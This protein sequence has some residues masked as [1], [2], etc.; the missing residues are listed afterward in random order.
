MNEKE[1]LLK[2]LGIYEKALKNAKDEFQ[3]AIFEFEIKCVKKDL[4]E[5]KVEN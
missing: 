2:E 1:K 5:L 4:S 3:K